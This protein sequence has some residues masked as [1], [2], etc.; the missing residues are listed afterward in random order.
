MRLHI[1][2]WPDKQHIGTTYGET[3][4][5]GEFIRLSYDDERY[6]V[7]VISRNYML[8]QMEHSDSHY[9]EHSVNVF[10]IEGKQEMNKTCL[11]YQ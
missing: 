1:I 11:K 9:K 2:K 6:K 5:V 7:V 3:P 10:V 4:C 8:C